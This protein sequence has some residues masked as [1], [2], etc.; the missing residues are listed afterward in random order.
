M[1]PDQRH[2]VFIR[3][4]TSPDIW[5]ADLERGG[6]TRVTLGDSTVA[7]PVFSPDGARIAYA[8]DRPE[9]AKVFIR[10]SNMAGGTETVFESTS[11]V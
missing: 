7:S 11:R 2:T 9:G 4:D 6:A 10:S 1:S 3:A 5:L 8:S